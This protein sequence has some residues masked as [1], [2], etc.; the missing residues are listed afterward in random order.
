MFSYSIMSVD[1]YTGEQGPLTPERL[2]AITE[3]IQNLLPDHVA[4]VFVAVEW[5]ITGDER[6]PAAYASNGN[7]QDAIMALMD[8]A[9][10]LQDPNLPHA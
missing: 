7:R 1:L 9:Q 3:A 10:K 2:A 8:V 6:G 4:F 5:G